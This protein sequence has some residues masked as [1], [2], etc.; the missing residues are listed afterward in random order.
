MIEL[1]YNKVTGEISGLCGDEKQFGNLDR[2]RKDEVIIELD[3]PLPDKS[4]EALLYD[5]HSIIPNPDY[6]EPKLHNPAAEID[7]LKDRL[8]LLEARAK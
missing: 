4:I 6:T 7:I 5:G 3:L 2:K 1:R 8:T